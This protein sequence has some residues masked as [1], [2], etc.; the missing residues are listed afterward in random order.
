MVSWQDQRAGELCAALACRSGAELVPAVTGLGL[1]STF[2]APK[3]AWLFDRDPRLRRRAEAGELLFGDVACWLSWK[4][5]AGAGHVSEPSN[6]CRTL[7]VNLDTL[8]WDDRLLDLF[9]VPRV[10][11]PEIRA[12]D[13]SGLR[14]DHGDGI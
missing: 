11:L 9:G 8:D 12:S 7:L 10:L 4:L 2:S 6:A 1:D 13:D 5:S 3:L 14:T